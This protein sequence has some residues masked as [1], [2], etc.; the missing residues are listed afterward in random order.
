MKPI[1]VVKNG[2]ERELVRIEPL[3]DGEGECFQED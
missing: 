2:E 3:G 1:G